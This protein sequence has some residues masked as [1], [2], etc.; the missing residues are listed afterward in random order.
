MALSKQIRLG[1][2]NEEADDSGWFDLV[3]NDRALVFIPVFS[4]V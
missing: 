1:P 2:Y 3:G 4:S